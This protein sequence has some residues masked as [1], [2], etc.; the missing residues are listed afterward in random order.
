MLTSREVLYKVIEI[1]SFYYCLIIKSIIYIY[2]YIY[3]GV[4]FKNIK[5]TTPEK[6]FKKY[7]HVHRSRQFYIISIN[8]HEMSDWISI[9]GN[10]WTSEQIQFA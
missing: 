4:H 3:I 10:T 7:K 1:L 5:T 2:I 8:P 6:V 9:T